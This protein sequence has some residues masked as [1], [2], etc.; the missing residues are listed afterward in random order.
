[1]P[2]K[3][4]GKA[5]PIGSVL[6]ITP[7]LQVFTVPLV[8]VTKIHKPFHR[9]VRRLWTDMVLPIEIKRKL[10]LEPYRFFYCGPQSDPSSF[11]PEDVFAR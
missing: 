8:G 11:L 7:I 9:N 1:M 4:R 3:Q 2:K 10:K 6:P 5:H